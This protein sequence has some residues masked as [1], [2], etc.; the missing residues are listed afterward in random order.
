MMMRTNPP[1]HHLRDEDDN[2]KRVLNR[3]SGAGRLAKSMDAALPDIVL[4]ILIFR[5]LII[6]TFILLSSHYIIFW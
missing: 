1:Q 2:D 4:S 5:I 3:N 6:I